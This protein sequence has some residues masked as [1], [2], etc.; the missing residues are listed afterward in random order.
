M[1]KFKLCISS[2]IFKDCFHIGSPDSGELRCLL[3]TLVDRNSLH[4]EDMTIDMGDYSLNTGYVASYCL[5]KVPCYAYIY[6]IVSLAK[7]LH[8]NMRKMRFQIILR[9]CM[10]KILSEPLLFP[11]EFNDLVS[12]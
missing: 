8:S 7:T 1:F 3:T 2:L 4:F 5:R 11:V 12:G 9:M 6:R 10:R